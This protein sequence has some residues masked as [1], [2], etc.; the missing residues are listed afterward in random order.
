MTVDKA[1]KQVIEVANNATSS[2]LEKSTA[3]DIAGFRNLDNKLLTT[4][5]RSSTKCSASD[6]T[7]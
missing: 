7:L 6:K 5:T 2:M 4:L 1:A 3:E